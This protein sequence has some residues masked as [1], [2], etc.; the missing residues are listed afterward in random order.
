[1]KPH[2]EKKVFESHIK[3][4]HWKKNKTMVEKSQILKNVG[5]SIQNTLKK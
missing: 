2:E 1:M 5:I 3:Y 4:N